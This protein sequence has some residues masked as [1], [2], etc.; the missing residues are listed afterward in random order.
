[1]EKDCAA[2]RETGANSRMR[3]RAVRFIVEYYTGFGGGCGR[4]MPR[5]RRRSF[6]S[7]GMTNFI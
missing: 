4:N 1:M 3:A 2:A 5:F 6:A 7:F